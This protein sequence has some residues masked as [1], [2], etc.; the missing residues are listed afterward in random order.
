M[1]HIE[2]IIKP[3]ILTIFTS[4]FLNGRDKKVAKKAPHTKDIEVEGNTNTP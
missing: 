3:T 4:C 2:V 1:C